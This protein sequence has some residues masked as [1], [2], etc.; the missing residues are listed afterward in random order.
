MLSGSLQF[1]LYG[2]LGQHAF[3]YL[4]TRHSRKVAR[5]EEKKRRKEAGEKEQ[6]LLEW[7]AGKMG[8][9]KMS[10]EEYAGLLGEKALEL[11]VEIALI[12][13][14]IEEVRKEEREK[15]SERVN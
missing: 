9:R 14:R 13:D 2:F 7:T 11:E 5:D 15:E 8:M 3:F 10:D 12:D 4:D 6:S 1:A